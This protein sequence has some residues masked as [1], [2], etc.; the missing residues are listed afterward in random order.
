MNQR[1][2]SVIPNEAREGLERAWLAILRAR[3]PEY[4]WII[5]KAKRKNSQSGSATPQQQH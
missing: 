5:V 4:E 2:K 3:H 1:R